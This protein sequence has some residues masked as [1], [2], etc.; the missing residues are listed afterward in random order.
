[1]QCE[2]KR[3]ME[4]NLLVPKQHQFLWIYSSTSAKVLC[5]ICLRSPVRPRHPPSTHTHTHTHLFYLSYYDYHWFFSFPTTPT[6]NWQN[7]L[8]FNAYLAGSSAVTL[9]SWRPLAGRVLTLLAAHCV[10]V[11]YMVHRVP[12][13]RL[14]QCSEWRGITWESRYLKEIQNRFA[15]LNN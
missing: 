13:S 7:Q 11:V 10:S 9:V 8:I 5:S 15:V 12:L 2:S 4:P 6:W 14:L 3:V 1:M